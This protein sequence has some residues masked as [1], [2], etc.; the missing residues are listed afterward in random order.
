MLL[1]QYL[2]AS[3]VKSLRTVLSSR[4]TRTKNPQKGNPPPSSDGQAQDTA[5]HSVSCDRGINR[6]GI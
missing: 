2:T 6:Q 3:T 4:E 5:Q 1:I